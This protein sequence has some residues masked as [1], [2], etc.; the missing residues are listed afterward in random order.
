MNERLFT[1]GGSLKEGWRLF[2]KHTTFFIVYQLILWVLFGLAQT[3][4]ARGGL[5]LSLLGWVLTVLGKMGF[6]QSALLVTM[7]IKP[8]FDQLYR[9][10]EMLFSWVIAGILFFFFFFLGLLFFII[11]G[12]YVWARYGFY[13]FFILDRKSEP[14]KALGQAAELSRGHVGHLFIL[15]LC[16]ACL[17]ILGL[18]L[19][20]LGFFVTLPVTLIALAH[21][22]RQ[23]TGVTSHVIEPSEILTTPPGGR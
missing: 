10:W 1:V 13:P 16:C 5:L 4:S 20:G 11:P 2:K 23:L 3:W 22:Y 21:T 8:Q 17:N 15:F 9:N 12:C 19:L 18:L 7:D 6:Y 14:L